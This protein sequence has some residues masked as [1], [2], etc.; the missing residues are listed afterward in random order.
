MYVWGAAG[1]GIPPEA[2][3]VGAIM[4]LIAILVVLVPEV[5]R[6]LRS[7]KTSPPA[8]DLQVLAAE[9]EVPLASVAT[10]SQN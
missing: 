4:F 8:S 3:V 2:N 7:N 1:R 9:G 5:A 6:R 10:A